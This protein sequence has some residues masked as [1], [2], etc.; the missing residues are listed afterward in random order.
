M[1]TTTFHGSN[2]NGSLFNNGDSFGRTGDT[3]IT[4]LKMLPNDPLHIIDHGS[5]LYLVLQILL[6]NQQY[7]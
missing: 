4:D 3:K 2:N 1:N 5:V 7:V 6:Y